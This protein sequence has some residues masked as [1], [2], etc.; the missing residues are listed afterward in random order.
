MNHETHE[1][2]ERHEKMLLIFTLEYFVCFVVKERGF[3]WKR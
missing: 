2:H 1:R 3:I